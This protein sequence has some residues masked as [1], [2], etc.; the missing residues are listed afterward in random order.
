MPSTIQTSNSNLSHKFLIRLQ[1]IYGNLKSAE[2]RA[3]DTILKQ[4]EF[5]IDAS[6]VEA[7]KMANCSETTLF[8]LAQKLG[9]SGYPELKASILQS[10]EEGHA[11]H[12][13]SEIQA[14]DSILT[15]VEKVFSTA[16]QALEDTLA[17]IDPEQYEQA[18]HHII[19]ADRLFFIGAGDAYTV[20]YSAYLKFSRIGYNAGCS[21]DIDV[22]LMEASRLTEKDTLVIISHSGRTQS[23][24]DVA[25]YARLNDAHIILITNYPISPIAKVATNV[26]LT[27]SFTPNIYNEIMAKRI[28]ELGVIETLY[29]N[30]LLH[31][32]EKHKAVLNKS[33]KAF[34][35]NKL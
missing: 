9:Y 3:A 33:N 23:L 35:L 17:L 10:G 29:I 7:A 11:E 32:N 14:E 31:G 34:S 20:A 4:P 13:Y 19:H 30:T 18:L 26:L 22:Q 6:I 8:R 12:L 5:I 1:S 2:K 15:V 24:Y 27:A 16:R 28:P 21:A 25:K